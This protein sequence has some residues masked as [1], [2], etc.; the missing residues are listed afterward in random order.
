[1]ISVPAEPA[2]CCQQSA[3]SMLSGSCNV[4]GTDSGI[5]LII[6]PEGMIRYE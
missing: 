2:E 1:M 5:N 3:V 4:P 6:I